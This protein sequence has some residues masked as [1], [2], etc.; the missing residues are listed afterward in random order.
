MSSIS[1]ELEISSARE[2]RLIWIHHN[3]HALQRSLKRAI[4]IVVAGTAL[5][6][7][8]LPMLLISIAIR[9]ESHGPAIL[10]QRRVKMHGETFI[11]HK[12][13]TMRED[14]DDPQASLVL[15]N[16]HDGPIFKMRADPRRTRLGAILR[17]TS[18]DELPNLFDV[19]VGHM[20]LVGPRPPLLHEVAAYDARELRRLAVKPGITGL[21][22][23]SGRSLLSWD[24]MVCLDIEYI[25][26]WSLWRDLLILIRTIPAV[27]LARGAY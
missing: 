2:E 17:K 9:L 26:T 12:F 10:R 23:V 19:L 4:D 1:T 14:A 20:S 15:E 16:E 18:I 25:A 5:L 21:W 6:V 7:L 13:R 11:F 24:E 3:E 22:Q 8:A 27:V